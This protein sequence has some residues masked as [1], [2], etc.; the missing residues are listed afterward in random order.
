MA[1]CE[2]AGGEYMAEC[3]TMCC[4]VLVSH[5]GVAVDSFLLACEAV[6]LGV[7]FPTFRIIAW[8]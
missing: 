7:R 6:W 8:V 5:S 2:T 1:E 4:K 3:E